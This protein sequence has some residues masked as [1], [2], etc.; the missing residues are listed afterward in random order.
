MQMG[1]LQIVVCPFRDIILVDNGAYLPP[2]VP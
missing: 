1:A 2:N